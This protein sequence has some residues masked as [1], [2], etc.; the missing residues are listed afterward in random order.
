METYHK[1]SLTVLKRLLEL[2]ILYNLVL[3]I[4]TLI[5]GPFKLSILGISI[6]GNHIYDP[7]GTLLL[8][9]FVRLM[10]TIRV[11]DFV[12]LLVSLVLSVFF[13]EAAIRIWNPPI[14]TPRMV[15]IHRASP[16]FGWELVPGASGIGKFGESYKINSVGFRNTEN[17]LKKTPGTYRIMVIGDSFTFGQSVNLEEAYP[18]QLERILKL[19]NI[20]CEVINCGTIGYN[21]WQYFEVLKRKVLLY[22]P[23]VV[24]LGLFLNDISESIA[25]NKKSKTWKGSNPFERKRMSGLM[26][27]F[28][29]SHLLS[30]L[31]YL[32]ES[33][34]RYRRGY[35]Y[36][37]G[38]EKRQKI[39]TGPKGK[40]YRIG[41]GKL[42]KEKYTEFRETLE[43]FI[44]TSRSAG[45]QVIGLMIPD[46]GQLHD[47]DKQAINRFF[48]HT[49]LEFGVP[50]IDVTPRFEMEKDPESLYLFPIDAHT[51]MKGHRLI[52]EAIAECIQEF[53]LFSP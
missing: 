10:L 30:N 43:K 29:L 13:A 19:E 25:P 44:L 15:Q 26:S 20:S 49:H 1:L 28:S 34:Y 24:V 40:W 5:V 22:S 31:N 47:P 6:K 33:K 27:Q 38:I 3:I 21:M 9:S 4:V 7:L 41:Y 39:F 52:A 8:L 46:A 11:K 2:G 17:A 53:G 45:T 16:I 36:L 12:L 37:Q 23:D 51:S 18:K 35:A 48:A 32:L 42:E 50:F 14:A